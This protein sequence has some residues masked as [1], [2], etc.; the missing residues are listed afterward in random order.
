DGL[1][2]M[3]GTPVIVND[4]IYGVDS[5][6]QFRCLRASSGERI[7]E[8]Q[9]LIKER[10]RWGSAFIV[11]HG[12]R[13]FINNDRGELVIVAPTAEGYREISRTPL[14]KPTTVP[15]NRR[16]LGAVNWSEPAYANRHIYARN[17]EEIIC[18]SL[19]ADER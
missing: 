18:A 3:N 8:S 13:L 2:A 1:H 16:E 19:A 9:A 17:D 4:H 6:G 14:I 10:A 12:D 7:W 5:F 11:R 15:T